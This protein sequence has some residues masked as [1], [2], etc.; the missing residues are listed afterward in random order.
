M[1]LRERINADFKQAMLNH[2]ERRKVTLNGLKSA[3]RYKEVEKGAGS[4]LA[5]A[6]IEA[7]V[8]HE[9]KSR[10]D[11]ISVYQQ[12]GDE[13]RAQQEQAERDILAEYL[14]PQLSDEELRAKVAEIIQAG[15]YSTSDFGRI[16]GQAKA[17]IG[18]AADGA[19][20]AA[21]VREYFA[22]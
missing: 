8:A 10:N 1:N 17:A 15:G 21:A 3:I 7:V 14:P 5:D 16:M 6:E 12:A 9:V 22:Q 19:A 11:S 4:Q 18:N 20:I 13:A 2:D